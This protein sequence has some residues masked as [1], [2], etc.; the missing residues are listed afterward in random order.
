MADADGGFED[1]AAAIR[2]RLADLAPIELS[3]EDQSAAHAGHAGA[4]S[5]AHVSLAL[6]SARFDGRTRLERHRMVQ[7]RLAPL[8]QGR[9][10]ALTMRLAGSGGAP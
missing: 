1:L 9:I 6:Q 4:R 10:H 5:G 2:A 7:E 8:M 3:I